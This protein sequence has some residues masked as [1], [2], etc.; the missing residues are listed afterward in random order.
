MIA[1]EDEL[2]AHST[3]LL[4]FSLLF[5]LPSV[6]FEIR[7]LSDPLPQAFWRMTGIW[8]LIDAVIA[9]GTLTSKPSADLSGTLRFLVINE[10]LDL[11]YVVV[12]AAMI[13]RSAKPM[14][15]GFG[16]AIII[17]GLFLLLLDGFLIYRL[18]L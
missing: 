2:R 1:M 13:W 7:K 17:Q 6:L 15:K 4:L 8:S 11:V 3:R 9:I 10:G 16:G 18:N 12:G 5:L 14:I